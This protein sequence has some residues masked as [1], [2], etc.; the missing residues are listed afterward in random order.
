MYPGGVPSAPARRSAVAAQLK[1]KALG[2]CMDSRARLA[3]L[4]LIVVQACHS[5]EEYTFALYEVFPVARFAS[6][7]VSS[8][9]ATGFAILNTALV[10]FGLWCYLVP[11]RLGWPSA[12]GWAWLWVII[13]LGNG[14]AHP[15]LA[16]RAGGY[17]PGVGT[18][19]ILLII[20]LYLGARLLGVL[21]S[22][23]AA[24]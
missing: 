20:A 19:P 18:A 2:S 21:G 16:F 17:F 13:E 5:I 8:D 11:V 3:F 1:A 24:A 23:R 9:L 15:A 7:L 4:A 22:A 6:G 12:R 14:L 10:V